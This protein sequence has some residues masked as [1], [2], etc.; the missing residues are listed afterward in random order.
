[1][2]IL[3]LNWR[4]PK[5]PAAGGAEIV[6]HEHAK[7]WVKAGHNVTFF[8]SS[9][10]GSRHIEKLDGISII[11]RGNAVFGVQIHAFFWYLFSKHAKFD[12][13]IDQ[14]H[15]IPFFTPLYM[16]GKKIA[17]IHEV[18]K[19]V[20]KLNPWPRPFNVI[21]YV[22]GTLGEEWIF[23]CFYRKIPFLTVSKS[24]ENDL[25]D[26]GIPR[27]SITIIHNGTTAPVNHSHIKKEKNK[28]V[29]FL[30]ALAT[31]KGIEDAIRI[32]G[33]LN[34]KDHDMR[35]WM[36][37][38]GEKKYL[39]KLR[40]LSKEL[41]IEKKL[42]FWGHVNEKKKFELLARAHILLNTSVREGWGLVIIEAAS[43]GTPA[44]VYDVPGLRDSVRDVI[45]GIV[46]TKR[47]L[48]IMAEKIY[49]L[50]ENRKAYKKMQDNCLLWAKSFTWKAATK[51]SLEMI[52]SL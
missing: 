12:L 2:N 41:G 17:F 15:G 52:Q 25:V 4:D 10:N 37:G 20:W 33:Y 35:F 28:T 7:A 1:M 51:K 48:G 21:P 43:Q 50:L 34:K 26:Y 22:L 40:K 9:Y 32:F 31:D 11:R 27:E 8:T 45:T 13:I 6:T 29:V 47:D 24:T 19:D 42:I 44:A 14:F 38:K 49:S 30:G 39:D 16:K 5:N 18:A 36:V 46:V 3:I 23:R